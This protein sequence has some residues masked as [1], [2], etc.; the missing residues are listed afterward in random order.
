MWTSKT[1]V[2]ASAAALLL[3]VGPA[4]AEGVD[5]SAVACAAAYQLDWQATT[6]PERSAADREGAEKTFAALNGTQDASA[7]VAQQT[8]ALRAQVGASSARLTEIVEACDTAWNGA[9]SDFAAQYAPPPAPP[10]SSNADVTMFEN[11]EPP[12]SA[13]A[14]SRSESAACETTDKRASG[15]MNQWGYAIEDYYA[16]GVRDYD[17]ERELSDL[18]R[19]LR[20]RLQD[21]LLVAETS[22]CDA[23]ASDIRYGLSDWDNPF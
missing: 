1:V 19:R 11:T 7:A 2:A 21:E 16:G 9:A 5:V 23:L 8:A 18:Y 20:S 17:Q 13:P 14:P 3:G 10:A 22:G 4:R 15:I 6:S 12:Y